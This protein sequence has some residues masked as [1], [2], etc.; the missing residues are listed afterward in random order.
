[1]TVVVYLTKRRL[2]IT[3]V[4]V[5]CVMHESPPSSSD[6][7]DGDIRDVLTRVTYTQLL[8]HTSV[9]SYSRDLSSI[10]LLQPVLLAI[11]CSVLAFLRVLFR[12]LAFDTVNLLPTP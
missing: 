5:L 8:Y 9:T 10:P 2:K 3:A 7:A 4:Y 1:V 6:S 11:V 12:V